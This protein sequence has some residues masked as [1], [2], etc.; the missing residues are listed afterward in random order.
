MH[1]PDGVLSLPVVIGGGV[2]AAAALVKA[3]PRVDEAAL[4]KVAVVSAMFFVASLINV[5]IGPTSVHLVLSALMGFVLGWAAVPAVFVGLVLQAVFFGFGG[6]T[7]L[8]VTTC[9]IALPGLVWASLFRP[10]LARSNGAGARGAWAG[11]A[12]AL[13][14]ATSGLMVITVLAL[15]DPHY[16][17]A[18][19]F[20]LA[21][22]LPLM[23][24]EALVTGFAVA[25][26]ARVR[27]DALDLPLPQHA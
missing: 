15:S 7:T 4:P 12:A 22:Y 18:A 3:L 16:L 9:T 25:F 10:L 21:T 11:L 20:V 2:V 26:L 1:I 6:L 19:P 24:G 17:A 23:A 27:P 14:I 5:P 8:G 13:S